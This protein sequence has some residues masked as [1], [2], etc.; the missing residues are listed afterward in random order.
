MND[1]FNDP[2]IV[3]TLDAGGTSFR[4]RALRTGR[5]ITHQ[6][7]LPSHGADLDLCL[8]TICEGFERI[9][10]AC[11]E[12]PVAISFA[13]PG[14]ADYPNGIIGDLPNLP[15]FRGGVALKSILESRFGIPVSINNDGD[16]F[17]YGEALGGFLPHVNELLREAGN[18]KRF[19]NLFGITIGTGLGGG[20]VLDGRLHSGDNSSA[21]AIHLFRHKFHPHLNAEEGACIRAVRRSYAELAGIPLA[22]APDPKTIECIA[23]GKA[24]GSKHAA[25][26]SF[27]QLG[28]MVGDVLANALALVD[29]LAVIGGGLSN[30]C[31]FFLPSLMKEMNGAY[32]RP[33][34]GKLW[35]LSY[36][37]FNLE[38]RLDRKAFLTA[39]PKFPDPNQTARNGAIQRVG[40]GITRLGTSNAIA[41]GAYAFALKD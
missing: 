36:P 5:P 10:S 32:T 19:K 17:A 7:V 12:K 11:P 15:A 24:A 3:M 30:A 18:P 6:I 16:L 2:R 8:K 22:D 37:A 41:L 21:G 28:E 14:P 4:F 35:R 34:G 40:V 1:L 23:R 20:L 13:F 27:S 25:V 31:R 39:T 29:G 26:Q 33:D 9:Q 38:D